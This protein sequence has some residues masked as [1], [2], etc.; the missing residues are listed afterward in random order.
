MITS[1]KAAAPVLSVAVTVTVYV[2]P[3][4]QRDALDEPD[5]ACL[6]VDDEQDGDGRDQG[7]DDVEIGGV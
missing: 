1:M 2:C 7:I 5:L 4:T 6:L 3:D